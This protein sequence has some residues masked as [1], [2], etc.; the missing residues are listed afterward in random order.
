MGTA[1]L[2]LTDALETATACG[3][4]L[5]PRRLDEPRLTREINLTNRN[6]DSFNQLLEGW[7]P[8]MYLLN[9]LNRGLGLQDAY[10]FILSG[11]AI[12]KLRL[13]HMAIGAA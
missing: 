13:V 4:S 1:F 10:P 6:A 12:D 11:A 3:L 7:F 9:N 5:R 8:L 2:H